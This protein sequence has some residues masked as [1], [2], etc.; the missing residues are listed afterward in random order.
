MPIALVIVLSLGI[1]AIFGGKPSKP[2]AQDQF[3]GARGPVAMHDMKDRQGRTLAE[4]NGGAG[5][6]GLVDW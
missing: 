3:S 2:T 1:A 5:K 4:T 6:G